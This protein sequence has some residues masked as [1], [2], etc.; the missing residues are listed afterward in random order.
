MIRPKMHRLDAVMYYRTAAV[1]TSGSFS[2]RRNVLCFIE[3]RQAVVCNFKNPPC[4]NDA[5]PRREVAMDSDRT[6]VQIPHSL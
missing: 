3:R 2:R 1:L 5:V 4:I 6:G